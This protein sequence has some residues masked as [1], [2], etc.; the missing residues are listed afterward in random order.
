MHDEACATYE[1]MIINMQLGHKFLH[2]NFG[3][4]PKIG[5]T[6]DPFGHSSTNA[7]LFAEMGF[8]AVFLGRADY[9]DKNR[10]MNDESLEYIWRPSSRTLGTDV[11]IFTHIL[12]DHYNQPKG[13]GFDPLSWEDKEKVFES[14]K[15]QKLLDNIDERAKHYQT[16]DIL[17]LFGDD[18]QYMQA[19]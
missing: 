19:D 6:I 2:D 16:D 4:Q 12:F 9:E 11:Q 10:R 13:F 14:Q 18:F 3:V 15:A 5:W 8:D 17:V 7:R 1:D